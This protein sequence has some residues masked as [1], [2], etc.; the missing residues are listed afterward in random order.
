MKA[1]SRGFNLGSEFKPEKLCSEID[2]VAV[3]Y[4]E[5][6]NMYLC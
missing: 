2:L 5:E 1:I 3:Q 6:C 4:S